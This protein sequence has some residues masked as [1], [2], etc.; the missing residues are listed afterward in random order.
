[1][2]EA[3]IR[4]KGMNVQ[5]GNALRLGGFGVLITG[6]SNSGKSFL[7]LTLIERSHLVG[8]KAALVGDDYVELER[9]AGQLFAHAPLP[10]AGIME[11]RGAG[12]FRMEFEEQ[13]RLDLVASLDKA[14]E[15]YPQERY[16]EYLG[17]KVPLLELPQLGTA[18][19]FALCHAIE[20]T[21]FRTCWRLELETK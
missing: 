15:R 7:T 5:H 18:D 21:L 6:P 11:I 3:G 8:R 9:S 13:V 4:E 2:I 19:M 16:F 1:M 17:V 20:A 10:I 14:G 12:L